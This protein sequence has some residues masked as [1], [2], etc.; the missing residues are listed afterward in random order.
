MIHHIECLKNRAILELRFNAL[1]PISVAMYNE[2]NIRK[3]VGYT[4]DGKFIPFIPSES[5]K[6]VL[7]SIARKIFKNMENRFDCNKDSKDIK[8]NINTNLNI[9]DYLNAIY[10][11]DQLR[12]LDEN[13]KKDIYFALNKCYVCRLFGSNMVTGKLI[14]TDMI[15][16]GD[17][18]N[19]TLTAINRKNRIVEK[20]SLFTVEYIVP[21]NL[22]LTIIA[23]NIEKDKE[24]RLLAAI[25]DY[26][27]K[28]GIEIGG[29]KSRGYGLIKLD[30]N[31]RVR[32]VEFKEIKDKSKDDDIIY[33]INALA[34]KEGYFRDMTVKEYINELRI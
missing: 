29:L 19:Y 32:I 21:D 2:G 33:N 24:G 25:L 28:L 4:R 30:E 26:M 13:A 5:I 18:Y 10:S 31:S 3:I 7:R 23:D 9:D 1:E 6:G 17:V 11:E 16:N 14:I 20:D 8:H 34:L 22:M 27:I 15:I 12:E